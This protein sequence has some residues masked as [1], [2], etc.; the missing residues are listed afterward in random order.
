MTYRPEE[1]PS[2]DTNIPSEEPEPPPMED[3]IAVS[4][5]EVEPPTPPP[6]PH[7]NR[8]TGDLL[9]SNY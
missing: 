1:G 9:V 5:A 2:E 3:V 7:D 6:P 8:D 4:N